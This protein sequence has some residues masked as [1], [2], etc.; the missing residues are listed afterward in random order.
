MCNVPCVKVAV[1]HSSRRLYTVEGLVGQEWCATAPFGHCQ[2]QII[3]F[4]ANL[5]TKTCIEGSNKSLGVEKLR[6][7]C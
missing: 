7:K 2:A 1:G 4:G 5:A 3:L 6:K